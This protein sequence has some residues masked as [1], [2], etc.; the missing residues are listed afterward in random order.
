MIHCHDEVCTSEDKESCLIEGVGH[1]QSFAFDGG[2]SRLGR[3]GEAASDKSDSPSIRA[4]EWYALSASAM[5][6]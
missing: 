5:F 4:A 6:L 1:R 3:V 2:I